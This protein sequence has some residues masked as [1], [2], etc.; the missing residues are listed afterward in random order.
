RRDGDPGRGLVL[1]GRAAG[2]AGVAGLARPPAVSGC[3]ESGR[4]LPVSGDRARAHSAKCARGAGAARGTVFASDNVASPMSRPISSLS[5]L[6]ACALPLLVAACQAP[7]ETSV[8]PPA[9]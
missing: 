5:T 2:G 6:F 8:M 4:S 1:A 9:G 3:R 7:Q